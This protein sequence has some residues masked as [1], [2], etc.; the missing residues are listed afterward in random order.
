MNNISE[1]ETNYGSDTDDDTVYDLYYLDHLDN[2][3]S[4]QC[5]DAEEP[6]ITKYNIVLCHYEHPFHIVDQR[7]KI[8]NLQ[9][10]NEMSR[11]LI[12]HRKIISKVHLAECLYLSTGEC[13]AI[14]KT[15][16]IIL[17]QQKWKKLLKERKRILNMRNQPS[18]LHHR[19]IHGRWP[20]V[21]YSYPSL[22]GMLVKMT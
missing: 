21:C 5:F 3:V 7:F 6:S 19:E 22:R 4:Y 18:S 1:I 15:K 12:L 10:I 17:I 16:W 13:V 20:H 11:L 8:F 14:K 9:L 2:E